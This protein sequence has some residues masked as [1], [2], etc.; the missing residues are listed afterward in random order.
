MDG[1]NVTKP[2]GGHISLYLIDGFQL[3]IIKT[4]IKETNKEE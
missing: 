1:F 2:A 3:A 4:G